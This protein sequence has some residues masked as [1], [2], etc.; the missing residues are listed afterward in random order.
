[1]S[2]KRAAVIAA[3]ALVS[4]LAVLTFGRGS[5]RPTGQ[6]VDAEENEPTRLTA[7]VRCGVERWPVKTLTDPAARSVNLVPERATV[8]ELNALPAPTLPADNTTRLPNE[9]QADRVTATLVKYKLESD[10]DIHVVLADGGKTMIAELPSPLCDR[11]AR[12]R[13]AMLRV[14]QRLERHLQSQAEGRIRGR[15]LEANSS[16]LSQPSAGGRPP[17]SGWNTSDPARS[18]SSTHSSGV[19]TA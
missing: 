8:A 19:T 18:A 4:T 12:A 5:V 16:R 3:L 10:E 2:V 15:T 7:S 1:M 6:R 14:R 17:I 11:G 13:R 9:R